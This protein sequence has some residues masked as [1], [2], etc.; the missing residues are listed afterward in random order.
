MPEQDDAAVVTRERL[1]AKLGEPKVWQRRRIA[2]GAGWQAGDPDA[3][4][5]SAMWD[6]AGVYDLAM[7]IKNIADDPASAIPEPTRSEL[8]SLAVETLVATSCLA[9]EVSPES[10]EWVVLNAC[11]LHSA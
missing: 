9:S 8:A 2:G 10:T 6:C 5:Q 11:K 4:V 1:I 3:S 7:R